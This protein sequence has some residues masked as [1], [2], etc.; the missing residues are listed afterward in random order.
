MLFTPYV[1]P[2]I[3]SALATVFTGVVAS[4]RPTRAARV[5]VALCAAG[6]LWNVANAAEVLASGLA[7]K[8]IW[9]NIEYPA[10][11]A[12]PLLWFLFVSEYIGHHK[13][14][15]PRWLLPLSVIPV[16]TSVLVWADPWLGLVRYGFRL[17]SNGNLT[18]VA[19][20][21]GPLFYVA[22]VYDYGLVLA[23]IA[24]L[25]VVARHGQRIYRRQAALILACSIVP[26]V[27]NLLYV[28]GHSP[29]RRLD[30]T[31]PGFAFS[32]LMVLW[33]ITRYQALTLVPAAH[34]RVVSSIGDGVVVLD[35]SGRIVDLNPAA[36]ELLRGS[37]KDLIGRRGADIGG[38]AT[39]L[40]RRF[41]SPQE[42][43]S[44]VA[45]GDGSAQ[46]H[47]DLALSALDTGG[48]TSGWVAVLRDISERKAAERER[49][50]LIAELRDALT[51][52]HDLRGLIPICASCRRIRDDTGYW[53][54]VEDYFGRY[55]DFAFT[56]GICPECAAKLYPEEQ[57]RSA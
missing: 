46:H 13:R 51:H 57:E 45:I 54:Q 47:F 32:S 41:R 31:A 40:A 53:Q 7:G 28:G 49:E 36:T 30:L 14:L 52:I 3:T 21:Y 12:V 2:Y 20:S 5:L 18:A 26:W 56:H 6:F 33:S 10:I 43:R 17:V 42:G 9:A 39:E 22:C 27:L 38:A 4:R 34:D 44:E 24:M 16:L 19:K 8:L 1:L 15:R 11:V 50:A 37:G 48:A 35:E 23:G 29:V 25:W 55:P